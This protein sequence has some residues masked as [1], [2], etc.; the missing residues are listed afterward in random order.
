MPRG[1]FGGMADEVAALSDAL[2]AID[3]RVEEFANQPPRRIQVDVDFVPRAPIAGQGTGGGTTMVGGGGGDRSGWL[4]GGGGDRTGWLG[5]GGGDR[6]GWIGSGGGRSPGSI[7]IGGG[8]LSGR[9]LKEEREQLW[10]GAVAAFQARYQPPPPQDDPVAVVLPQL[11]QLGRAQL[12]ALH[13][14]LQVLK[15]SPEARRIIESLGAMNTE[16]L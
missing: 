1:I 13:L 11:E 10:Q 7:M 14:I 3:A 2:D 9:N 15:S 6:S 4:G 12:D 8:G 16:G 5:G